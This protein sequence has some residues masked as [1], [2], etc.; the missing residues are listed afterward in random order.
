VQDT[1]TSEPVP[2]PTEEPSIDPTEALVDTPVPV[3]DTPA[4]PSL[5][6]IGGAD[7]I[8]FVANNEIHLMNVDGSEL[9]Q[10][11]TDGGTKNDLQWIDHD[12]LLFLSGATVKY[13]TVSTDALDTL[14]SFTD[15][16]APLDA[17]QVS[18]DGT[19]VIIARNNEVFV[20]P[21]DFERMAGIASRKDLISM[22]DACIIP[23]QK[24]ED[25]RGYSR[26]Q[27]KEARWSADDQLV[28]WL[29][30]GVSAGNA[31]VQAK[32]VS[33]FDITLCN[34]GQIDQLHNFPGTSFIPVGY[35]NNELPDFD[36]NGSS[37]FAFISLR[38]NDV[39]GEF[40][41]YDWRSQRPTHIIPING[42]CCYSDIRWS[43]DGSY[44]FFAFQAFSLASEAQS[45]LYYVPAGQ[46]E[47]GANFIPLKLSDDFV[48]RNRKESPQAALRPVQR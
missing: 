13:Y 11:T 36:W 20:V 45:E 33:V 37:L 29:F 12:T 4:A 18:H 2:Q 6:E 41:V 46:I 32:Q 40:Y 35:V 5:P 17:F 28:A 22:E 26:L 27:V 24:E 7:K 8:A 38:R 14:T 34:P 48:F 47:T 43:P 19:K 23:T 39:W 25:P 3:A 31:S 30:K 9:V 1:A 10:L 16:L 44:I 21:F 15:N 42:E